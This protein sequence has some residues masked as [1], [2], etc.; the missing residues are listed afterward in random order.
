MLAAQLHAKTKQFQRNV[1]FARRIIDQ[2]MALCDPYVACSFGK[3]SSVLLHMVTSTH[4]SVEG[5]FV[6]WTES[7]MLD[8][9]SSTLSWWQERCS[10]KVLDLHRDTLDDK[11]S[12]R[13][14]QL[15][16]LSP[17]SGYFIGFRA[18]ESR[19]RALTLRKDGVIYQRKDGM[20]RISPLA[21]WKTI[22]I[23]AYTLLHN[24]P[25]LN[26]YKVDG[27]EQRTSARVPRDSVRSKALA[28]LKRRD[29]DRWN[30]LCE[31]YPEARSYV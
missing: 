26:A 24:L 20:Y 14:S 8:D 31:A 5:R 21:W 3:D 15:E 16:A 29:I 1:E 19:G 28:D 7:Q 2:A 9:F 23:A 13:W 22:D 30:R 6:R 10:I 17:A 27:F 4:P 25:T 11:V 12:S 18:E